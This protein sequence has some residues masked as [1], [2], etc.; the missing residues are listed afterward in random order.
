MSYR[1]QYFKDTLPTLQKDLD[2]KNVM[3][4]P[5]ITKIVVNVGTGTYNKQHKKDDDVREHIALI[6]GQ[7]PVAVN[8]RLSISNFKLREGMPV[9]VKV[10]LRGDRMYDFIYKLVHVVFPRI[11][12]F[13]GF[14]RKAFDGRGNY[15]IGIRDFTIFPEINVDDAVNIHGLQICVCTTASD[16]AE[17][18]KLLESFRFP[19]VKKN[20]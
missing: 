10:T 13:R 17:G 2:I 1:Q 11:R 9:G 12:D 15:S 20:N 5:K 6:T 7:K 14:S 16:N 18:E 8:A 4:V 3:A 19:F